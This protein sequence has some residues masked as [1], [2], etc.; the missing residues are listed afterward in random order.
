MKEENISFA[1]VVV[2]VFMLI[3]SGI[4]LRMM[5][6]DIENIAFSHTKCN[7][8]AGTKTF[9]SNCKNEIREEAGLYIY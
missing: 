9:V 1:A 6:Y 5:F 2:Q 8:E 3:K 4:T 7:Y